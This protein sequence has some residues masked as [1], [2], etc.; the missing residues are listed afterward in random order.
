M[1]FKELVSE[2]PTEIIAVTETWH[3]YNSAVSL[4]DYHDIILRVRKNRKLG[5]GVALYVKKS[6]KFELH[7][8]LNNLSM[9]TL[10]IIGIKVITE[11]NKKISIAAVYKPPNGNINSTL[12]DLEKVLK[13]LEMRN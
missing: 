1:T 9:E 12:R 2:I 3:P 10:E 13:P 4:I 6:I 8:E 7:S 11:K 5:G